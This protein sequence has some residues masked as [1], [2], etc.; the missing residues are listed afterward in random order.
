MPSRDKIPTLLNAV[1]QQEKLE[2]FVRVTNIYYTEMKWQQRLGQISPM[3]KKFSNSWDLLAWINL[4]LIWIINF[5]LIMF[6]EP[7]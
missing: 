7:V 3:L 5:M 2:N 6:M 4:G 1:S